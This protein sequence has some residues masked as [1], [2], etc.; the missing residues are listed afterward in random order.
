MLLKHWG[1]FNHTNP[2]AIDLIQHLLV[3]CDRRF[4]IEQA[5]NHPW[6]T[7]VCATMLVIAPPK[8]C[9][10]EDPPTDAASKKKSS[11]VQVAVVAQVS[12]QN[13]VVAL[14]HLL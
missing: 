3:P 14:Q 5:M 13:S 8:M 9:A 11:H 10:H 1:R 6:V 2:L 12:G 4:S 7:G